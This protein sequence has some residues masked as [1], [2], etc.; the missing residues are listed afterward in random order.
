MRTRGDGNVAFPQSFDI[1]QYHFVFRACEANGQDGTI[2][3]G[4]QIRD[5]GLGLNE[6]ANATARSFGGDGKYVAFFHQV[7][8]F[9]HSLDVR[10]EA[11]NEYEI[12]IFSQPIQEAVI[13]PFFGNGN[14]HVPAVERV[15]CQDGIQ[16][17]DVIGCQHV[18]FFGGEMLVTVYFY[19]GDEA[20]ERTDEPAEKITHVVSLPAILL[21][22]DDRRKSRDIFRATQPPAG[23]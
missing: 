18:T 7:D 17:A 23:T 15:E 13:F 9:P 4:R 8:Q 12:E 3:F 14:V 22:A 21:S 5:A 16:D 2:Q 11:V 19:V 20:D 1:S 6:R 10:I